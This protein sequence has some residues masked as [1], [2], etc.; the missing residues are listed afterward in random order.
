MARSIGDSLVMRDQRFI[1]QLR[2]S[3]INGVEQV[4]FRATGQSGKNTATCAP[5]PATPIHTYKES[6]ALEVLAGIEG[7]VRDVAFR[8]DQLLARFP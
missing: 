1:Q 5:R 2:Q 3:D 7:F 6:A 4:R 8:R